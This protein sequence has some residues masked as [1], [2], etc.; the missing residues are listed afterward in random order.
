MTKV[1]GW[2]PFN[3]EANQ[4]LLFFLLFG[5]LMVLALQI[6]GAA[7]VGRRSRM[8]ESWNMTYHDFVI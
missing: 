1:P 7:A 8:K 2:Q 5:F 4:T 6:Q 3:T